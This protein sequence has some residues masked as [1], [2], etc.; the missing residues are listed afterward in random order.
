MA[1]SV[2]ANLMVRK[3][4]KGATTALVLGLQ[5]RERRGKKHNIKRGRKSKLGEGPYIPKGLI[6]IP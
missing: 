1:I 2:V 3:N 5:D 6:S 4:I